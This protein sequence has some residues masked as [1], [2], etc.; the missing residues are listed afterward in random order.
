[1][2]INKKKS[3]NEIEIDE[4][5]IERIISMLPWEWQVKAWEM[6]AVTRSRKITD[7][8]DLLVLIMLYATSGKSMGGTSTILRSSGIA[9]NK[10]AVN[11]RIVKSEPWVRWLVEHI[12]RETGLTGERPEWMGQMRVLGVDATTEESK[13]AKRQGWNLHYMV[14][15]FS[16]ESVEI[17]L[18]DEKTGEK[19]SN[20]EKVGWNDIII[21]DRAY[22][23]VKSIEYALGRGADYILR[24]KSGAFN[25]YGGDGKLIDIKKEIEMMEEETHKSMDLY[26][27][28]GSKMK[29]IRICVYRKKESEIERSIRQTKKSNGHSGRVVSEGQRFYAGY[30]IVG[31]SLRESAERVLGLY[32][33][34]WQIE[35]TFKR[36]KGIIGLDELKAKK[37]ESV[38]AWFYCKLLVAAICEALDGTARFSPCGRFRPGARQPLE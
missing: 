22:G 15:I 16:L 8:R 25:L 28:Q 26:Y 11:E 5:E 19:L 34:R 24:L 23:T 35:Q 33:Q 38:R 18:S 36:L 32:R 31:T 7:A 17:K 3:E 9:M 10:N 30:V 13:D 1:M 20:F 4:N 37:P 6:G 12:G 21:G 29:P 27:K 2:C 14:D